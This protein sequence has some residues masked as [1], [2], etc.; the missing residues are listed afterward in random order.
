MS[1]KRKVSPVVSQVLTSPRM[2]E[3]RRGVAER[4]RRL[5]R[6]PHRVLY[7][8]QV[9]DPY[10]HL[11]VQ[12][13]AP[14]LERYDLELTPH[15]V[16]PPIDAAAPE[17][18][19]LVAYSRKDAADVA[20]HYGLAFRDL[21]RQPDPEQVQLAGRILAGVLEEGAAFTA[22]A[23]RVGD[24]LWSE[25]GAELEAVA[26]EQAPTG[27]A[28]ARSAIARGDELRRRL[29]HY[30]GATFHY[31]GEWY[32][33]VDRLHYLER[34]LASEG[35]RCPGAEAELLIPRRDVTTESVAASDAA[36][37][38]EFFPS[39]RSPYSYISMARTYEL[40]RRYPVRLVV[41][42]VLPM[43]MRGLPVP[44]A[45]RMY[46]VLDT[47][48]EADEVG[49]PFG[50]ICDPVGR[51]VER[52]YSLFP[53]AREQ[54]KAQ[55]LLF[56]FCRAAFGEGIDTGADAGLQM[57]V[58]RAGLSWEEA[59]KHLDTDAWR[60]QIE[61]NRAEM[62]SLGLWGVPSYRLRGPEG[63]PDLCTWGQDRI[64]LIEEEIRKRLR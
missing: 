5:R 55:E 46:I 42:P 35:V 21:G 7:F 37:S 57:V 22:M 11:T 58:E 62:S 34:R 26:S 44:A 19:Q 24:A 28:A 50:K 25:E 64:W 15:L 32:W 17:R 52:C 14:L 9:D 51:P 43:V 61:A 1:L 10:S 45:K 36:L 49:V 54:G 18:E 23:A 3:L 41:R 47:K 6:E 40:A 12:V 20:P 60:P 13:L 30:L 38:L 8:H 39:I 31:G 16:S 59:R 4:R 53:W 48:R 27:E 29:G 2:R 33:G 56:S 63:A